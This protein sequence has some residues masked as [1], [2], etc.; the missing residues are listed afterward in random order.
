MWRMTNKYL[1]DACTWTVCAWRSSGKT[2]AFVSSMGNEAV[3]G[4]P[5]L[6]EVTHDPF[7]PYL[8]HTWNASVSL[9]D[10]SAAFGASSS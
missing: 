5:E 8:H 7:H 1:P 4:L 10:E 6:R 2:A 9:S 3:G